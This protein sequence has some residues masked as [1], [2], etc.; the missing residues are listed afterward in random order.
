MPSPRSINDDSCPNMNIGCRPVVI[1]QP[2][3]APPKPS[4]V[5]H[6]APVIL[7]I[8]SVAVIVAI[9]LLCVVW[10]TILCCRRRRERSA[11]TAPDLHTTSIPRTYIKTL[12]INV[13]VEH[14]VLTDK[15]Q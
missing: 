12:S 3:A 10:R 15:P 7:P 13:D 5:Y 1:W 2:E 14:G 9:S 11:I 8:V 4:T 6:Q